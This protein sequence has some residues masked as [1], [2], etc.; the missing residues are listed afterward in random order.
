M[1][2]QQCTDIYELSKRFNPELTISCSFNEFFA[3]N[4]R[5]RISFL[6]ETISSLSGALVHVFLF[7]I[8]QK[9]ARV[10]EKYV[11]KT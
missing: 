3:A 6:R 2:Q 4:C 7:E 5:T 8:Y 9:R 1:K 10:K 11:E